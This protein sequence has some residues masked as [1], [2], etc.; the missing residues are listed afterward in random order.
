MKKKCF[1]SKKN[2][3]ITNKIDYYCFKKT[4][5]KGIIIMKMRKKYKI[6]SA[7]MVL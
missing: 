2:N 3:R 1:P 7:V 4:N 5:Q 6:K